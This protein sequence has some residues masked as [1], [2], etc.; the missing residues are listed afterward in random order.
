MSAQILVCPECRK[1]HPIALKTD[2]S[3]VLL[4]CPSCGA[5][6]LYH[7]GATFKV[8][9]SE[10]REMSRKKNLKSVHELLEEI[11][12][13]R[14]ESHM[15]PVKLF[16]PR[17]IKPYRGKKAGDRTSRTRPLDKDDILNVIIDLNTSS[18]VAEFLEKLE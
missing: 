5:L 17:K 13:Q 3:V 18:S 11:A 7:S 9:K 6:L 8:E 14:K 1:K 15:H 16:S 2:K 12:R 10:I 4:N